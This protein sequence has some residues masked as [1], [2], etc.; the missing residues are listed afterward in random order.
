MT[1]VIGLGGAPATGK[2]TAIKE[3]LRVADLVDPAP[4]EYGL[5]NGTVYGQKQ[6][7]LFG[8]YDDGDFT[9]TDRLAMNVAPD[10]KQFLEDA[11]SHPEY[12]N[13]TI[14]FEGDRLFTGPFIQHCRDECGPENTWFPILT[15]SR[16][17]LDR[18]HQKR[19]D[20]QDDAWLKGRQT[21]YENLAADYGL[22]MLTHD[23]RADLDHLVQRLLHATHDG[24]HESIHDTAGSPPTSD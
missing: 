18:R 2:S 5:L 8:L 6:V 16:S 7:I 23:D 24:V 22:P 12:S 4:F 19:D 14:L 21:K 15:T 20:D 9:G 13:Y 1:D 3:Y 10:A 11:T 17:E